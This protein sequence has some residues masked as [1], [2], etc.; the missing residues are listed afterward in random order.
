MILF[1]TILMIIHLAGL[2]LAA[3]AATVKLFLLFRCNKNYRFF[4][5]YFQVAGLITA[6][7][8]AGM[9]L[10]TLSGICWIII[11]YSFAGLLILKVILV[12]LIWVLGPVIDN[13]AEPRL[14]KS[15]PL[16]EEAA[17]PAFHRIRKQHLI[18]EI[19]ATLIMYTITVIG[20][21]L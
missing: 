14:R 12:G 13:V 1:S 16:P 7:I 17:S 10:L 6:L 4:P 5:V 9:I 8:I 3:G 19:A 15:A 11:G 18:L 20:V 2:A 21:L